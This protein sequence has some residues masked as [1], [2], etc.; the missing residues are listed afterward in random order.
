MG[1]YARAELTPGHFF[2]GPA[3]M[4][5]EDSTTW[6]P[7]NSMVRVDGFGNLRITPA[8]ATIAA[9]QEGLM[10]IDTVTLRVLANHCAA[11]SESMANTLVRTASRRLSK[12]RKISRLGSRRLKGRPS[13]HP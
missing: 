13:H 2:T 1:I 8:A 9:Q 10:S 11:A 5:L 7:D 12:R 6:V 4:S 3:I